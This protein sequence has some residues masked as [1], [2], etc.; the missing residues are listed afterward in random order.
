MEQLETKKSLEEFQAGVRGLVGEKHDPHLV[1]LNPGKLNQEDQ[2]IYRRYQ[3]ETLTKEE[4]EKYR[5]SIPKKAGSRHLFAQYIAN[6]LTARILE[7]EMVAE[8]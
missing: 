3:A 6:K 4:F 8:V 7:A 1:L 5:R 2:E